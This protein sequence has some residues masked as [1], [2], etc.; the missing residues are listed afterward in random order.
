M[1]SLSKKWR[2]YVAC[3]LIIGGNALGLGT[4]LYLS[5]G[6]DLTFASFILYLFIWTIIAVPS[7]FVGILIMCWPD[8]T[9]GE[10]R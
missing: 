9:K 5:H 10:T 4:A 8:K 7:A 3:L 2:K 6:K 1:K